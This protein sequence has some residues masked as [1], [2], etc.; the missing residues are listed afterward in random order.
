MRHIASFLLVLMLGI[1][2]AACRGP[3][4]D[5]AVINTP[6]VVTN[7]PTIT[8]TA[9][10]T[11]VPPTA[12]ST[13][14]PKPTDTPAPVPPTATPDPLADFVD[15]QNERLGISLRHPAAWTA[16]VDEATRLVLLGVDPQNIFIEGLAKN[17]VV[18]VISQA[19]DIPNLPADLVLT[20]L[21]SGLLGNNAVIT[22]ADMT[23]EVDT[24]VVN[25]RRAAFAVYT[26]LSVADDSP[27]SVLLSVIVSGKQ[28]VAAFVFVPSE[29]V[30]TLQ[31]TF[32]D[33]VGSIELPEPD[34]VAGE[35]SIYA[36]ANY[37]PAR[38]PEEDVADALAQAAAEAKRVL[39]IVGGDWCITCHML[40]AYIAQTPAVAEGLTRNFVLVKVNFSEENENETFLGQYPDIEWY[41]HF[42]ILENDGTLVDSYD[43]RQLETEGSYDYEKFLSFLETWAPADGVESDLSDSLFLVKAYDPERDPFTD[44][45]TA[46]AQA[47]S[48]NKN[49]L[50]IVGGD[51]CSWC[52]ILETFIGNQ[53][54]IQAALAENFIILKINYSEDNLNE[55]FL[56]QY[57]E[58]GGYPHFYVLDA[59]GEFLHSQDTVELEASDSYNQKKFMDFL[60]T[61]GPTP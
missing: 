17:P 10:E 56:G 20:S 40:E 49:I 18:F 30:D 47:Q 26:G 34:E 25:G 42:F 6:A 57:P 54:D 29:Q 11:P 31:P 27:L 19:L 50:L 39:L 21:A 12:T 15:F 53:P 48:K 44:L 13:N 58:A 9:T 32:Q 59:T 52:H 24:F 61:W 14:T 37:D 22:D 23:G 4:T 35:V 43:T 8:P 51:W 5:T 16:E 28:I 7:T 1:G 3:Q 60:L 33:V 2:L 55:A 41:P 45:E 46:V 36:V 38:N